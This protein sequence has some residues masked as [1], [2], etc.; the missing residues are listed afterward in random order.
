MG[1]TED[2]LRRENEAIA[3]YTLKLEKAREDYKSFLTKDKFDFNMG[4]HCG[5]SAGATKGMAD[6]IKWNKEIKEE[7]AKGILEKLK[8]K[9]K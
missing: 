4:Y 7:I 1:N 9:R 3:E 6:M 8:E 5:Y 2:E